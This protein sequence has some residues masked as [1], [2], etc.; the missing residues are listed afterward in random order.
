MNWSSFKI[1]GRQCGRLMLAF[2]MTFCAATCQA[3]H[4]KAYLGWITEM[5]SAVARPVLLINTADSGVW[6]MDRKGDRS[7]SESLYM[8]D[9]GLSKIQFRRRGSVV[10]GIIFLGT[11]GSVLGVLFSIKGWGMVQPTALLGTAGGVGLG[12]LIGS[13]RV[14]FDIGGKHGRY[15][16]LRSSIDVYK[17]Q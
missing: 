14:T 13:A 8:R 1:V 16:R 4:E 7:V 5:E 10:K 3:Q 17:N 15:Q 11:I 6:V 9:A 2:A 12:A